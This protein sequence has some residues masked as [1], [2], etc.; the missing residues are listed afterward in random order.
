[1]NKTIAKTDRFEGKLKKPD[2]KVGD[3][4]IVNAKVLGVPMGHKAEITEVQ[5]GGVSFRAK[6]ITG[7]KC[8]TEHTMRLWA[9]QIAKVMPPKPIPSFMLSEEEAKTF[10]NVMSKFSQ[11]MTTTPE[12]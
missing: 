3:T 1:M 9:K 8:E 2:I 7:P 10:R 11:S 12:K 4:V 6:Y 5:Y